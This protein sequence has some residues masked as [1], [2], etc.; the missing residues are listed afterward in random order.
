MLQNTMRLQEHPEFVSV[1][2]HVNAVRA[3]LVILGIGC[4]LGALVFIAI[5]LNTD[6]TKNP[7]ALVGFAFAFF[8][9]V[10]LPLRYLLWNLYG[11]EHIIVTTR[12][13]TH[14]LS[15]G[16]YRTKPR[17]S[18]HEKLGV[19]LHAVDIS[20]PTSRGTMVLSTFDNTTGLPTTILETSILLTKDELL[21]ISTAIGRLYESAF[22]QEQGFVPYSLN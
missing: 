13:V 16:I 9:L 21:A 3:G 15:Y 17:T 22:Q 11:E 14:Q 20:T 19:D 12:S 5:V 10:L 1:T 6:T 4:G 7:I 18:I 2:L 8:V